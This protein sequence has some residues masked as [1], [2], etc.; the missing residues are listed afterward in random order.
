MK[1]VDK[2]P[3]EPLARPIPEAAKRA[4]YG[5]TRFRELIA[6][7]KI[8]FIRNGDRTLITDDEIRRF[9][10]EE[11]QYEAEAGQ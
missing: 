6:A 3:V 8:G 11:M 5:E 1:H 7:G 2:K 4:G 10:K 9:L